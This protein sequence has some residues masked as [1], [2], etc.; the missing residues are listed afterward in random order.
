MTSAAEVEAGNRFSVEVRDGQGTGW[1]VSILDPQGREVSAR[2]CRDET[3]AMTFA[4]TVRQHIAWLSEARFR[5]IY[6]LAEGA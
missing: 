3:E 1:S 6:R 2:A 5:E 4:S